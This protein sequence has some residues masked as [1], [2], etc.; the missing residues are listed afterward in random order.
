MPTERERAKMKKVLKEIRSENTYFTPFPSWKVVKTKEAAF[1]KGYEKG[2]K[3]GMLRA[4]EEYKFKESEL[5]EQ[6]IRLDAL[7]NICQ[8]GSTIIESMAKSLLSYDKNL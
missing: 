5:K 2:T 6:I 7:K 3:S 8:V 1:F 4:E